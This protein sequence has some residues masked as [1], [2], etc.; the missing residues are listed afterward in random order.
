MT[1]SI[2]WGYSEGGRKSHA[3]R[4]TGAMWCPWEAVC[5]TG[6]NLFIAERH[7]FPPENRCQRCLKLLA[8]E[9]V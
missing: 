2:V 9:Q 5:N 4:N 3:W 1:T 7:R 8:K 6:L